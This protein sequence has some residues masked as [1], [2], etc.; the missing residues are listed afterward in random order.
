M[1]IVSIH[2]QCPGL[3]FN[4]QELQ[5]F[6][7]TLDTFDFCPIPEGE[8]S[9]AFVNDSTLA[10]LH[11]QF[12][13]NP[14]PTDVMTFPGDTEEDLAGEICVSVDRAKEVSAALEEPFERELALYLIHGWLHLAGF[15]DRQE[16]DRQA[17]RQAERKA[18]DALAKND[19][20]PS[21]SI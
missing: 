16:S 4:E 19:S 5:V 9:I 1:R 18:L 17:M 7:Q 8:L 3:S 2:N 20:L 21:F 10:Q 13:D 11:H 12:M 6:F 14:A 15:D